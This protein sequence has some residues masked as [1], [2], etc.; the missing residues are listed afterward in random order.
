MKR[1][2]TSLTLNKRLI[3]EVDWDLKPENAN[4]RELIWIGDFIMDPEAPDEANE[5]FI[6]MNEKGY[7]FGE[8]ANVNTIVNNFV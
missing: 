7:K 1:T 8:P 6:E 3:A 5:E 2:N 4:E